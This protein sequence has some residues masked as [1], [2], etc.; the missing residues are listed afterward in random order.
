LLIV[1]AFVA[2]AD[3][4]P[5]A[6]E[7]EEAVD[8]ISRPRLAPTISSRRIGE[9]FDECAHRLQSRD[10]A[11]VIVDSVRTVAALSLTSHVIPIAALVAEADRHI[12]P[13]EAQAISLMRLITETV[14]EPKNVTSSRD[15]MGI[16]PIDVPNG[17]AK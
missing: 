10:F 1:A 3:G 11:H 15:T 16:E 4:R 7:R 9:V 13:N 17:S 6:V 8:Y 5:Q 2:L 14:P 12:D